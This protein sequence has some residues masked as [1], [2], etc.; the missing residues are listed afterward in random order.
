MRCQIFVTHSRTK[1]LDVLLKLS[2]M[3][4]PGTHRGKSQNCYELI[5]RVSRMTPFLLLS[6]NYNSV[7]WFIGQ[8]N[9]SPVTYLGIV[10]ETATMKSTLWSLLHRDFYTMKFT[11]LIFLYPIT[12]SLKY[13]CCFEGTPDLQGER[14]Y[15]YSKRVIIYC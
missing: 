15:N 3:D 14:A 8:N 9:Y 4:S 12:S 11:S 7:S 13:F 6:Y 5:S 10:V 1:P 2:L